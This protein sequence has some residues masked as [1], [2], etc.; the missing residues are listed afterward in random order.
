MTKYYIIEIL[1]TQAFDVIMAVVFGMIMYYLLKWYMMIRFD[2][3]EDLINRRD[4]N[5]RD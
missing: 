3:L 1:Q 2:R 4:K 5:V